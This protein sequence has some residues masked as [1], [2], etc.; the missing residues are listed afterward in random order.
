MMDRSE[1]FCCFDFDDDLIVNKKIGAV[2]CIKPGI[3]VDDGDEHLAFNRYSAQL[4]LMREA[5]F[6]G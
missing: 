3:F 1:S 4:Q 2:T 6:I 5:M